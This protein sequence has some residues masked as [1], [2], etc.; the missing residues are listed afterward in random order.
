MMIDAP[1]ITVNGIK[2]TPEQ[3]SG[4]VQYHPA[5]NLIDAKYKAMQALVIR[6]LL[7]QQA[8]K[9]GLCEAHKSRDTPD[10]VIDKLL[11]QE[12]T[13]PEPSPTEC[14]RYYSNNIKRF[15]TSP[16]FEVSHILYLAPPEDEEARN[17]ARNLAEKA[18]S[19]IRSNPEMFEVIARS[20]SSCPSAKLGGNLG[21]ISKGQTLPAFEAALFLMKEG[22]LSPEPALTEVGY[23]IIRLHRRTD[24][25]LLPF[26]SVA[27]WVA[28]HLKKESWQRAFS[29]YIQILAG[30]AKI[31]G[32]RLHGADTPLVQ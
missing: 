3:I 11:E 6:E 27:Q 26:D 18:L 23:H 14:E 15:Y 28:D 29:Q 20:E 17:R 12:I 32:F 22:D 21:Q 4:E 25:Q 24:G 9:L 5:Q 30:E 19:S 16:L 10:E 1:G 2:I 8:V 13:V 7:I 31:S